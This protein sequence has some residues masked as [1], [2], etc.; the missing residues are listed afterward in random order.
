MEILLIYRQNLYFF[1]IIYDEKL[2]KPDKKL[3]LFKKMSIFTN[4]VYNL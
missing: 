3:V 4:F 1:W 2:L